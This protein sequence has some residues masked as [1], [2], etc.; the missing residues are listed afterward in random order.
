[1]KADIKIFFESIIAVFKKTNA[2]ITE[3][4]IK[5]EINQL[6]EQFDNTYLK[7]S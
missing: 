3:V 7:I 5:E 1:M 2:E 6:K 4:G